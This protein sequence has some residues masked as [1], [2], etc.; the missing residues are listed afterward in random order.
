MNVVT[1][2]FGYTGRYITQHLLELGEPV[3]ALT[4]HPQ[5]P[6]PF[7]PRVQAI[8]Y[9]FDD[10]QKM[11]RSLK[12]ASV[13]YNTYWVRF[14][15]DH[16]TYQQAVA[17]SR[18]LLQATAEAGI[19]RIVHIS[20]TNASPE[21]PLPYFRGKG[22]VEEA[23]V[24][25]GL[26]YAILRPTVVFGREDILI[27]NIAWL[28]RRS[29][30]FGLPGR[31]DYPIQP[32]SVEDVAGLA[33]R[34]GHLEENLVMDCVGPETFAFRDLVALVARAVGSRARVVS[35]HPRLAYL[36]AWALG[37]LMRDVVLTW[38]EVRGLMAGLLVSRDSPTGQTPFSQWLAQNA[39]TL[40][41]RYA[42][43]LARHFR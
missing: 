29:P 9:S 32:V 31:G 37:P 17:N 13:L 19:R 3:V 26:S 14:P 43:E 12:G 18:A 39:E 7:G 40:G 35:L 34:A 28:L 2:A 5:R 4:G 33:V 11:A 21:S 38:D 20:I 30:V 24:R 1:G 10:P 22:Q 36:A 25:S 41:T 16:M 23:V 15:R 8:P 27:N 42:S 6:S